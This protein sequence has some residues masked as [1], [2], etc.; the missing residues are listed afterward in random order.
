MGTSNFTMRV[1]YIHS[2]KPISKELKSDEFHINLF[3]DRLN[4]RFGT[5]PTS[6]PSHLSL[7]KIEDL[8]RGQILGVAIFSETF[9]FDKSLHLNNEW[10]LGP[11]CY[12][13]I[14]VFRFEHGIDALG[15]LGVWTPKDTAYDA[16][17][18]M[19]NYC[20]KINEWKA[21]YG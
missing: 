15:Q 19:P 4:L 10:N 12:K 21:R 16:I 6:N 17:Q 18:S 5:I 2:G 11:F 1:M 3:R 20:A 14:D 9:W 7:D 8:P 13:I